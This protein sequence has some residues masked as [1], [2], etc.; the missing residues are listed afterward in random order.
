MSKM[1][2]GITFLVLYSFSTMLSLQAKSEVQD[3]E[4]K[5]VDEIGIDG[6]FPDA[7]EKIEEFLGSKNWTP[8]VNINSKTGKSF[9]ISTGTGLQSKPPTC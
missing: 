5:V 7:S 9:F 4:Y 8:G 3:A 1:S 6:S 2:I